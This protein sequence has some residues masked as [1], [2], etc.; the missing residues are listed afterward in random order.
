MVHGPKEK[1]ERMLGERLGL[2]GARSQSP[3]S[4]LVRKPYRPG[5]H[6]PR[7]RRRALSDFGRQIREKQKF[8]IMYGLNERGLRRVFEIASKEKGSTAER[9]LALLERRLDNVVFRLGIAVSRAMARQ[10]IRDGH[11]AV[12]GRKVTAPG[13]VV[14]TNDVIRVRP[15]SIARGPFRDAKET[16]QKYDPPA[17]LSIDKDK[18]EGKVLSPPEGTAPPFEVNLLVESFSK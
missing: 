6:G 14:R 2:K 15:E 18:L 8:K 7:G 1:K 9:L 16:L 3:K 12:N 13:Y 5:V 10:L 17:W 11:I 4:A